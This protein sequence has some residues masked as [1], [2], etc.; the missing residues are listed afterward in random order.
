MSPR[1]IEVGPQAFEE[2][3][4]MLRRLQWESGDVVPSDVELMDNGT[5][6]VDGEYVG[7]I[8]L[9]GEAVSI[10]RN[11]GIVPDFSDSLFF[12]ER[13]RWVATGLAR[14]LGERMAAY[15]DSARAHRSYLA[16][17]RREHGVSS[18]M[19]RALRE[20]GMPGAVY[21]HGSA[22]EHAQVILCL[23]LDGGLDALRAWLSGRGTA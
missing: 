2:I 15:R 6:W 20:A 1:E 18:E 10:Q 14:G 21:S 19:A 11:Q 13:G 23:P 5:L 9:V 22:N 17:K 16:R 7:M 12:P 8:E 4:E 3:L